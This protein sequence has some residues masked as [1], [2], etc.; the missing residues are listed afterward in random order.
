MKESEVLHNK[1]LEALELAN[2]T[3]II[4]PIDVKLKFYAYYK[5]ATEVT[6]LY[7]PSDSIEMRNSF[8]IN[9]IWQVQHLSKNEAKEKYI[10]MVDKYLK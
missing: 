7:R 4:L 2:A 9:A 10:Q 3:D 6:D 8:K 1:F 5:Q